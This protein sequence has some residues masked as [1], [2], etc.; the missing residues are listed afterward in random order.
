[1]T[2]RATDDRIESSD[3]RPKEIVRKEQIDPDRREQSKRRFQKIQDRVDVRKIEH[4]RRG[5]SRNDRREDDRGNE[6]DIKRRTEFDEEQKRSGTDK[7]KDILS[8]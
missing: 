6:A 5:F 1:M 7:D 3:A 2:P 4:S 8:D